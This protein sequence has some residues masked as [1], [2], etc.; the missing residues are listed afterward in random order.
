MIYFICWVVFLLTMILAVAVVGFKNR[1]PRPA[2][3]AMPEGEEEMMA[4]AEEI[5]VVDGDEFAAVPAEGDD[6]G[7]EFVAEGGDDFAAFEDEF[8]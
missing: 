8:K 1:K 2:V 6:F 5:E 7:G 3:A 4:D